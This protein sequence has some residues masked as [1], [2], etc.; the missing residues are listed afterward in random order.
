MGQPQG[1]VCLSRPALHE[2]EDEQEEEAEA[3][4]EGGTCDTALVGPC[5][6]VVEGEAARAAGVV[7][8][9]VYG[10]TLAMTALFVAIQRR[11]LM[12]WAIF[13]PKLVYDVAVV[14]VID[15]LLLIRFCCN[16]QSGL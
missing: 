6:A 5:T 15:V 1:C 4:E 2:A 9:L 14:L 16:R 11:H 7:L 12:V 10:I 8:Q 13:A 3:E